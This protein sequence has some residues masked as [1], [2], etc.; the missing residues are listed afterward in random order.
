M[1]WTFYKRF[2]LRVSEECLQ[3]KDKYEDLHKQMHEQALSNVDTISIEMQFSNTIKEL[4]QKNKSLTA[5]PW[6][7]EA[8]QLF[9]KH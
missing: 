6:N 2:E 4:K 9:K 7:D 3:Y 5:Q 1:N 8:R